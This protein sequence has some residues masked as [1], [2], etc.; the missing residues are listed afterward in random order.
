MNIT[1][2]IYYK[3]KGS[4]PNQVGVRVIMYAEGP[5]I[6]TNLQKS[7]FLLFQI[8]GVNQTYTFIR[9]YESTGHS[10]N[11]ALNS[12]VYEFRYTV[13]SKPATVTAKV[14]VVDIRGIKVTG[15]ATLNTVD[16]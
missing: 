6:L 1:D 11:P 15:Q 8:G 9:Y 10:G 13:A 3:G 5:T 4:D 7:N 2:A 14:S 12:F 16:A